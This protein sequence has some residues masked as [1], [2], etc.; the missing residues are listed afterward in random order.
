MLLS[1]LF[2]CDVV[3]VEGRRLGRVLDT[4]L[5]QNGPIVG[6]FGAQLVVEGI[7]I[8][9][10]SLSERLGYHRNAVQGPALVRWVLERIERRA[11]FAPW[12]QVAGIDDGVVRLKCRL[13]DL[14][15]LPVV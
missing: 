13:E 12:Q 4:L 6:G 15:D 9:R 8:G 7:A 5:V 14:Q 3:D 10:A 2:R 11:R 1:D